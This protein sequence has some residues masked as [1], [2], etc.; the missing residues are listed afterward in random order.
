VYAVT[1]TL[2]R[3]PADRA[4]IDGEESYKV[5]TGSGAPWTRARRALRRRDGNAVY[6]GTL[7]A[8]PSDGRYHLHV[9]ILTRRSVADVEKVFH[10]AGLDAYV[11]SPAANES[12]ERF[13]AKKAAY[14][15]DNAAHGPSARFVASRGHGE[16]YDSQAAV[17]RRREAVQR[18]EGRANKSK[19]HY[20]R[21]RGLR[22]NQPRQPGGSRGESEAN[23]P[24]NGTVDGE[25][26]VG[27]PERAPPV[28]C[29]GGVYSDRQ[30][31]VRAVRKALLRRVGTAVHVNHVGTAEL[32]QVFTGEAAE[33]GLVECTVHVHGE[34]KTRS[35]HWRDVSARETPRLR[36]TPTCKD[37]KRSTKPMTDD[38]SKADDSDPVKRFN[39]AARYSKV[40]VE[41]D[42]GRRR[43]T[44]KDHET[45]QTYVDFKPPRRDDGRA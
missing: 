12:A 33:D 26:A 22:R 32:L 30:R 1:V 10:V 41:M 18:K 24:R 35:V 4:G 7:S 36:I 34:S 13:A 3:D 11:Q 45:G 27:S 40:T 28:R 8:R 21:A 25:I 37:T 2:K 20:S 23:A 15:F 38:G 29:D 17:K 44:V 5:W 14:A 39:N 42:D 6:M 31:Y 19:C 43:V 9:L 16:G